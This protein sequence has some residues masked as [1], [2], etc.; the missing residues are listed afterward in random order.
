MGNGKKWFSIVALQNWYNHSV[1]WM[2]ARCRLVDTCLTT[3][4]VQ[5]TCGC[6]KAVLFC[7][8]DH[9]KP[10]ACLYWG[11]KA[12]VINMVSC[13]DW[14]AS[15]RPLT[16]SFRWEIILSLFVA[17]KCFTSVIY[18]CISVYSTQW[19]NS[20]LYSTVL[21]CTAEQSSE[22]AVQ[23]CTV[24]FCTA[25][26]CTSPLRVILAQCWM[27][28]FCQT[29]HWA[30]YG[31]MCTALHCNTLHCTILHCTELHWT[32]LNSRMYSSYTNSRISPI[33][34]GR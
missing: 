15:F 9:P 29:S 4:L 22:C 28:S 31:V 8:P 26:Q 20:V 23:F 13:K 21:H 19:W 3:R 34:L 30:R 6:G 12:A 33:Y 25:E 11:K 17:F 5:I 1:R 27:C 7:P 2:R 18:W 10:W 32:T 14:P 16:E 24:Q